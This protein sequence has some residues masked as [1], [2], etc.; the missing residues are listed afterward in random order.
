MQIAAEQTRVVDCSGARRRHTQW[1]TRRNKTIGEA[2]HSRAGFAPLYNNND[3]KNKTTTSLRMT[4]DR[5][6]LELFWRRTACTHVQRVL[7]VESAPVPVSEQSVLNGAYN[8]Q[9]E[10]M[11]Y[12]QG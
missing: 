2:T 11:K 1:S 12:A 3:N 5:L 8:Q 7:L 10:N 6:V 4:D 9:L